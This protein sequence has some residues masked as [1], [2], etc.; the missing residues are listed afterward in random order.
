[1]QK[2]METTIQGLGFRV[3]QKDHMSYSLKSLKGVLLGII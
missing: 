2:K 3:Y 1:M